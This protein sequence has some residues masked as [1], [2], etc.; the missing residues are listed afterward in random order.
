MEQKTGFLSF[1]DARNRAHAKL[2]AEVMR[3][4]FGAARQTS[5]L[6]GHHL[7]FEFDQDIE[8]EN[9][10][11]SADTLLFNHP[12]MTAVFGDRAVSVMVQLAMTPTESRDAVLARCLDCDDP[13]SEVYPKSGFEETQP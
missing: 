1:E 13:T 7:G 3:R 8:T 11:P 10:I 6:I 2:Y 5:V 4:A 12:L 9:E